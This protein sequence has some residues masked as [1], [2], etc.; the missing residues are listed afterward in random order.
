MSQQFPIK[1]KSSAA[2]PRLNREEKAKR[3]RE[4]LLSAACRMVAAEGY[5]AAAIARVAE[6]AGVAQGTFYNYFSD[7]QELFDNILPYEGLRMRDWVEAAA[8]VQQVGIERE[9]TRFEAFLDYV[10]QYE[11]FYRILYEAEIF[12]PEAHHAHNDNIV[13]GYTRNFR[14]AMQA[15]RM[16]TLDDLQL[17]CL[18]YQILGM[19]AYAA[20]QIYYADDEAERRQIKD[21]SVMIYR[22]LIHHSLL[23]VDQDDG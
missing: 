1:A 7:R 10:C 2:R 18:I 11:G 20:K 14:R 23:G 21:A 13:E 8:R 15:G 9:I 5:A 17:T 3:T 4:A 12:A 6:E 19:R 22:R 16:R